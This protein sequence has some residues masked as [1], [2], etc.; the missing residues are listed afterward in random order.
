MLGNHEVDE[1]TGDTIYHQIPDFTFIDQDSQIVTN[2]TFAGKAYVA[3]FFFTSCPTICPKVAQQMLRLEKR[4]NHEDHL[5]LLSHTV[6][7]KRDTVA[8][9]KKYQE[10]LGADP[11]KWL[12]VTG[13]KSDIYN[14]ASDYMSL[15]LEDPR[16]PGGFDHSGWLI[17]VD[18]NRHIRAF[19]NG[20]DAESVDQF[21]KD[22]DKLL[23]EEKGPE[24]ESLGE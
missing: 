15:A 7:V 22:I 10:G 12:F 2:E 6:D 3:D 23:E 19:A 18:K 9:L 21:M 16:A 14:I 11:D 1:T 24:E 8:K 5:M 13:E 4:Y 17:L 20:T